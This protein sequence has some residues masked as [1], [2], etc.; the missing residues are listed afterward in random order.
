[1]KRETPGPGLI[2]L[3]T[4][5]WIQIIENKTRTRG[6]WHSV[7]HDVCESCKRRW[8][9][10][11]QAEGDPLMFAPSPNGDF[12]DRPLTTSEAIR[13]IRGILLRS[14][15]PDVS[16][17]TAHSAKGCFP[18]Y[19]RWARLLSTALSL[20][21]IASNLMGVLRS[22]PEMCS[23]HPSEHYAVC[24][25][26]LDWCNQRKSQPKRIPFRSHFVRR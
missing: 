5:G 10:T 4:R 24:F 19:Q 13:W 3:L 14:G 23:R 2:H 11:R 12:T 26:A 21:T 18:C 20:V 25:Q 7:G 16:S 6:V 15:L 8:C 9:L 1:M 17:V 22:T